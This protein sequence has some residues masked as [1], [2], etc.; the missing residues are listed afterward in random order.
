MVTA[1]MKLK[2]TCFL[3]K[4]HGK[5]RQHIKKQRHHFANRGPYSQ[6]YDL[7]VVVYAF[8]SWTIR[9]LNAEELMLSICGTGEDFWESLG[10]RGD[11][12]VN[13]KGDQSWI[14]IG[15]TDA[16]AE[17]PILWP[18]DAK[19]RFIGKDPDA[20]KDWRKEGKGMTEYEMV[21]WHLQLNGHEFE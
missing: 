10:L 21:G 14:F 4:S 7:P 16:E 13:P 3:E 18:P 20:G 15:R 5:H 11:E 19:I 8:A 2:D 6:N 9:R 1:A 17:A 12:P